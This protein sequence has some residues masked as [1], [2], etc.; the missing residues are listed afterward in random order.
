VRK[1]NGYLYTGAIYTNHNLDRVCPWCIADGTAHEKFDAQFTD[2][3][4]IGDYGAWE[5]VSDEIVSEIAFRTP[6]FSGWQQER[7]FT[8]CA[9]AAEHL[10]PMGGLELEQSGPEAIAAI[11]RESELDD[12]DWEWF[13]QAMD[14]NHGPTAYLF[15]CRHCGVLDGYSDSH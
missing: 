8:H 12:A 3:A 2:A 11:K 4:A 1:G 9:D 15:R 13:F 6:G 7:W 10:G 5:R 14:R